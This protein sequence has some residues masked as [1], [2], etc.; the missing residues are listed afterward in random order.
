MGLE[1]GG[2]DA[3]VA[4]LAGLIDY[5]GLFPPAR[6][7]MAAAVDGYRA[8]RGGPNAWM[9]ARF[10]CPASRLGELAGT[11]EGTGIEREAP[12]RLTVTADGGP[13]ATANDARHIQDFEARLEGRSVVESVEAALPA[14]EA[15]RWIVQTAG[16]FGRSVFFEVPWRDG[17]SAALDSIAAAGDAGRTGLGAKLRC[18]GLVIEA[19]PPPA[20]VASVI[21]GCRDRGIPLKATAGLHH[22]FRHFDPDTGFT[23]H[24]FVNLLVACVAADEG[25]DLATITEIVADTDSTSFTLDRDRIGWHEHRFSA[26][27]VADSR[28]RLFTGYGSC[29]LD[30][31][32]EDLLTLGV[33]PVD[34]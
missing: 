10:I 27:A 23:H 29:S 7:D 1:S 6:L 12:W 21:A 33:L 25:L 11:L 26:V 15:A 3:R 31:P 4:A 2:Q 13:D 18:G 32:V 30:E 19:F 14:S 5:A 9:V 22:P 17:A 20:M 16:V 34:G 8:A 24:G 28:A